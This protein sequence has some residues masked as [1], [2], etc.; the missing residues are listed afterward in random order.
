MLIQADDL[1]QVLK[2][3]QDL[4]IVRMMI[5]GGSL[6]ESLEAIALAKQFSHRKS[7]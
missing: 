2:R 3:A 1:D 6:S 5:T 4:G 7:L